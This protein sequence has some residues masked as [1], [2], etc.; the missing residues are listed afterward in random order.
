LNNG[1]PKLYRSPTEGN[2]IVRL[3]NNSLSPMDQVGRMLHSFQTNAYEIADYNYEN[4]NNYGFIKSEESYVEKQKIVQ[5][6]TVELLPKLLDFLKI[7][8]DL[9]KY[10]NNV[11][12]KNTQVNELSFQGML[13]GDKIKITYADGQILD[14]VIG[15]TGAY[16]AANIAPI[17]SV[18][19]Y[20][21]NAA[22]N[23]IMTYCHEAEYS[24]TFGLYSQAT[25]IEIPAKQ[26]F[27]S[28]LLEKNIMLDLEDLKTSILNVYY[29][30]FEKRPIQILYADAGK[31]IV[32]DEEKNPTIII[33]KSNLYYDRYKM[34]KVNLNDLDSYMLYQ[35]RLSALDNTTEIQHNQDY[36]LD[37]RFEELFPV[38]KNK[39]YFDGKTKTLFGED[40]YSTKVYIDNVEI[41]LNETEDYAVVDLKPK[42]LYIGLGITMTIGYGASVLTYHFEVDNNYLSK[43]RKDVYD[44]AVKNYN[45]SILNYN[46][47][48][49]LI[50][51]NKNT[52]NVAYQQLLD[53]IDLDL[54]EYKE[55]N[56]LGD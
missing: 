45:K 5:W 28:D 19:L 8:K 3:M 35:I 20:G 4:L 44:E 2:Y 31:D 52:V 55:A 11:L 40:K 7:E 33:D 16:A 41:D 34:N 51:A 46:G 53:Q 27:G 24:N 56:G 6:A 26:Y 25:N 36:F 21:A 9:T 23:G 18:Q 32:V 37:N 39:A 54:E 12:P 14:I 10:T 47:D 1:E 15:A 30:N 13:P 17:S 29:I 42:E 48:D 38:S 49:L 22:V 50:D 43:V